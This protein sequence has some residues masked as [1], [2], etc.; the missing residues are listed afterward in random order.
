MSLDPASDSTS[1]PRP[2]IPDVEWHEWGATAS[3][4]LSVEECEQIETYLA[5]EY[6]LEPNPD[7]R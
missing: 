7:K 6:D 5:R 3:R 2:E 4:V 1:N